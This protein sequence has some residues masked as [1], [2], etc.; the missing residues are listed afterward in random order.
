MSRTRINFYFFR[1][2]LFN[3]FAAVVLSA[4]FFISSFKSAAQSNEWINLSQ[5]Y[6]KIPVAKTGIYR[7]TYNDLQNAGVPLGDP[8]LI[9]VF[10][11]GV[12]Q[13]ILF[14]HDQVPADSKFDPTE[15]FEFYGEKN[16]GTLDADLYKPSSSQPHAY[17]NLYS[18]T[19][20]YFL[21]WN[22]QPIQGKRIETFFENNVTNIPKETFQYQERLMVL[23]DQF[24]AGFTFLDYAQNAF[25]DQGEGWTGTPAYP[26]QVKDYLFDLITQ[27][28]VSASAPQLEVQLTGRYKNSHTVEVFVGPTAGSMRSVGT[29]TFDG[30]ESI[31]FSSAL[32][33]SDVGSDGKLIVRLAA[34]TSA[35]NTGPQFSAGYLKLRFAQDFNLLGKSES[36]MRLA[37]NPANKSYAEIENPNAGLRLWDVTD[38]DNVTIIGTKAVNSNLVAVIPETLRERKIFSSTIF[39]S[40]K[41]TKVTFQ[42]IAPANYNYL[43][44]SHPSLMKSAGGYSDPVNAYATYRSSGAGGSYSP[45]V[46]TVDQLYNQFNYGETSPRAIYQFVK[47]MVENGD[48]K[49]L[50]LIGKG[51]NIY[52]YPLYQRVPLSSGQIPDLVPSAGYPASDMLYS[53]GLKGTQ[54][55]PALPTGRIPAVSAG[56]VAAYLDKIKEHEA[57]PKGQAWRKHGL[58]LSGGNLPEEIPIFKSYVEG[59]AATAETKYWGANISI[60]SKRDPSAN[61]II[62]VSDQINNGTN[63]VVFFGHASPYAFDFDIGFVSDPIMGYNNSGKYPTFLMNGCSAGDYFQNAKIYGEDWIVAPKKGARNYIAHSSFGF[64]TYLRGYSDTFYKV[65]FGDST[66]LAKGIGDVQKEVALRYMKQ[67]FANTISVAQAQQMVLLGDPAVRLFDSSQPDYQI[68]GESLSVVSLDGGI[69]TAQKPQIGL[70]IVLKNVGAYQNVAVKV[71]VIRTFVDNS[72]KTYDSLF[73]PVFYQDTLI[74]KMKSEGLFGSGQNQFEVIIDPEN[75]IQEL[76]E[77]NN[78]VKLG[79]LIPYY[80]TI[81]LF[82]LPYSIVNSSRVDLK[83]QDANLLAEKKTF[84]LEIDTLPDF[85][86]GYRKRLSVSAQVLAKVSINLLD[87]DSVVYYWRTRFADPKTGESNEWNTSSFTV[88]RNG[89]EGWGQLRFGQLKENSP[90]QIILNNQTERINYLETEAS[91]AIKT[92]GSNNPTPFRDVSILIDNAEYNL[93][94]QGETCRNNSINFIAFNKSTLVPYPGVF[95]TNFLDQRTCGREPQ[96][97]NN[98]VPTELDTNIPTYVD[99]VSKS[100]S[101]VIFSIGNAGFSTWSPAVIAKLQELGLSSTQLSSLQS[102]EPVIIMTKKGAAPGAAKIYRTSTTP[103]TEQELQIVETITG[104]NTEGSLKSVL[105]GPSLRW[106]TFT[107]Q[108]K[109]VSANDQVTFSIYGQT[110]AGVEN[111]LKSGLTSSTDLSFID[112]AQ[113]PF[114][115]VEMMLKDN[116]DL[117]AAQLKNWIVFYEPAPEGLLV[118]LGNRSQQNPQ[119]GQPFQTQYGFV[120]VSDKRFNQQLKV[121]YQTTS[122]ASGLRDARSILINSP[123]P[124]D[125]SKFSISVDTRLKAGLNDLF[126]N[127]NDRIALEN[128]YD[129]NQI[130]LSNHL[131]IARDM[132]PPFLEVLVEGRHLMNGDYVSSDPKLE[133]KLFDENPFLLIKDASTISISLKYPCE[134][135]DCPLMAINDFL[136]TESTPTTP[137]TATKQ[138]K[139]LPDGEYEL[140]IRAADVSGNESGK[141]PYRITFNVSSES[142][143][144]FKSVYPNPSSVGFN[145]TFLLIGNILPDVFQLEIFSPQGKLIRK[146]DEQDVKKFNIGTNRIIWNG[147]DAEGYALEEGVYLYRLQLS[148]E[149]KNSAQQGK[150]MLLR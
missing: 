107:N 73:A 29:R 41:I 127:V 60:S 28:V 35:G 135:V 94:A 24:S 80:N 21:T 132:V 32:L 3:F 150:L 75:K 9:Q 2:S 90:T 72:V 124:G 54:Y 43:I 49:Y 141:E 44:I 58:H 122:K 97:I 92:F 114:I 102:G 51:R 27:T 7:I 82:P 113:Y 118:F 144:Q 55:E 45:L 130:T 123:T 70:Q 128:Y 116:T 111:L 134:E 48:P 76:S 110:L 1:E 34:S 91:I 121:D 85:V 63:M 129:N 108:T 26:G 136:W 47:Y 138:F 99:A 17:Y 74:F 101:V 148:V 16:D 64:S 78:Q 65:G 131:N 59:F 38:P 143:L 22:A 106:F 5:A 149:G 4:C 37:A 87:N 109:E 98:F 50:L 71:K 142:D 81:N 62:N 146:F 67:S 104:R 88:I 95:S 77:S 96:V 25:F 57:M 83:F 139:N 147:R 112:A 105:I 89:K 140:Q 79:K 126:V 133:L 15:Y 13:A 19:A 84:L 14:K 69:L 117:T 36:V 6:Y 68:S 120:N 20:A 56:E 52:D 103:V 42:A 46:V 100:D 145:F 23:H 33:W 119:E 18:D 40:S 137:F 10:H 39:L 93:S 115:R 125:T 31:T 12:E 53:I 61:Q 11:R 30:Y 66:Y 86:S 8:R